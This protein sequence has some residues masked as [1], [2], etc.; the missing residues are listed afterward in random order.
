M[1]LF[2]RLFILI[3]S[4]Q[5]SNNCYAQNNSIVLDK[6]SIILDGGTAAK[7]IYVVVDQSNPSGIVRL[8]SGVGHINSE[9]QYNLV[10]WLSGTATGSYIFPFGVGGNTGDYLPFTFNKTAGNSNITASTWTTSKLNDPKPAASNVGAVTKMN[11]I[12]DPEKYAIDRFWNIKA[13]ATAD[14]TFS[15]RGS[16]NTTTSLPSFVQAQHWNGNSWDTPVGPG[17]LEVT[18]GIGMVGP[19]PNQ[20]TFS[21]WVLITN[22]TFPLS[23]DLLDFTAKKSGNNVDVNWITASEKNNAY[24]IVERS[25]GDVSKDF[26]AIGKVTSKGDIAEK[27]YYKIIDTEPLTGVNYYRLKIVD[28]DRSF[29]YSEVEAVNFYRENADLRIIP[30]PT[31]GN[32]HINFVSTSIGKYKIEIFSVLEQLVY[33]KDIRAVKGR[34]DVELSPMLSN[35]IYLVRLVGNGKM[36]T[37]KLVVSK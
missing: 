29:E 10:K 11:G 33:Q 27:N 23:I 6:A 24:F 35:G 2:Y 36:M 26:I 1:K 20:K 8:P 14:L 31:E 3:I 19:I 22:L 16:E 5:I 15:Y 21:P 9:N 17:D 34:N 4:Y 30:N 25:A 32:F 7:S 18:S 28:K 37:K 12:T 13:T